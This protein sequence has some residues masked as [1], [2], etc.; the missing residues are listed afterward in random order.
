[1]NA[2]IES[3]PADKVR[4]WIDA[5]GERAMDRHDTGDVYFALWL[6]YVDRA[7]MRRV[8]IGYRDLEDWDY[9]SAYD[10]DM[11]PVQAAEAALEYNGYD[12]W[13]EE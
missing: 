5:N 2:W 10:G 12:V 7:V 13:G 6:H 8:M 3:L 9:W 11:T 4:R 1:M